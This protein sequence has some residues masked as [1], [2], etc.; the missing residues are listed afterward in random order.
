MGLWLKCPGCQAKNTLEAKV[1]A[2]CGASLTNLPLQQRVYILAP[3]GA[4]VS[5]P[6]PPEPEKAL[7]PPAKAP[8]AAKV[9]PARAGKRSKKKK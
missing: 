1:C 6:L 3:V 2:A 5:P 7:S 8:P 9:K 4:D